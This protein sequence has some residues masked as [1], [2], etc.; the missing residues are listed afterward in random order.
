MLALCVIVGF[1]ITLVVL[2][3][4]RPRSAFEAGLQRS[5]PDFIAAAR[6]IDAR[7]NAT[8]PEQLLET[9][10][11]TGLQRLNDRSLLALIWLRAELAKRAE[12]A[13]CSALA[14]GDPRSLITAIRHLPDSQ[15]RMWAQ[16][17]EV[18]ALSIVRNVPIRP[19]PS[20]D[21]VQMAAVRAFAGLSAQD[22]DA[23]RVSLNSSGADACAGERIF[24]D[25]LT[26]A[27]SAD[28]ILITRAQ[29]Y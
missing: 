3:R 27:D 26:R 19:A 16:L 9:I 11:R 4:R 15:Q 29:L 12:G 7:T 2:G 6:I 1:V 25:R 5:Y 18:A 14:S 13:T 21:A 22:R 24:Y 28:A 23:L 20:S 8:T 10:S 17:F